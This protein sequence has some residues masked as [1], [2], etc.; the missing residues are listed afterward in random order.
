M[1]GDPPA[2]LPETAD[3][4]TYKVDVFVAAPLTGVA[5]FK[6]TVMIK[7]PN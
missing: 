1:T 3:Q 5:I 7:A 2:L 6:G 4:K